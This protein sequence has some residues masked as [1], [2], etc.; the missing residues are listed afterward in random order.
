L[1]AHVYSIYVLLHLTAWQCNKFPI[2]VLNVENMRG[3]RLTYRLYSQQQHGASLSERRCSSVI[4]G[5]GTFQAIVMNVRYSPFPRG[6]SVKSPGN[7]EAQTGQ[8]TRGTGSP[9]PRGVPSLVPSF[10]SFFFLEPCRIYP[11]SYGYPRFYSAPCASALLHWA[12]YCS[13]SDI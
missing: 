12:V 1:P 9:V 6:L 2:N 3:K 7:G 5:R 8:G 13:I 10:S 4:H 11:S